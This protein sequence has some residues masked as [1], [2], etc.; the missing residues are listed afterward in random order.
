MALRAVPDGVLFRRLSR[1]GERRLRQAD[2]GR[3]PRHLATP[4]SASAPACSSSLT[5]CSKCPRTCMLDK[6]GARVWIARIMF[7]WGLISGAMAFIP[8]IAAD[9]RPQR[10]AHVLRAAHSARLRRGRFLPRHHL[11]PDA[12][13]PRDLSRPASSAISWR[14]SRSPP[15]SAR[16]CRLALLGLDGLAG[17]KGWQWLYVC[18]GGALAHPGL[19]RL[20]SI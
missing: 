20:F 15:R 6:F 8:D 19:R 2:D 12:V 14:R 3:R 16:Q 11:F 5:S 13:V 9:H 10:R 17:L 4:P 18:G 7:S 1:P